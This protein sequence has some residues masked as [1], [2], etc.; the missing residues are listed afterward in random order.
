MRTLAVGHPLDPGNRRFQ[1]DLGRADRP[2]GR[3]RAS[4]AREASGPTAP[5]ILTRISSTSTCSTATATGSTA[6]TRKTSS[7]RC[8][9][10]RSRLEPARWFTSA[11]KSPVARPAR[12]TLE[13]RVNYRKFDRK[14]M[15]YVFGKGQGPN[16]PVVVMASDKVELP[17]AG[18]RPSATSPRR[19]RNHGSGGM[20]TA[21]ACCSKEPPRGARRAS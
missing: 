20:T 10:S 15:D 8:T 14:Y 3:P 2:P 4:A 1:R 11:W 18:G 19:S 9:T 7:Y 21:S 5:S 6:A 16:L 12:S 13:A 17:V